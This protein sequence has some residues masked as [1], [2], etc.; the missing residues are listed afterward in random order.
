M[1][2]RV[3]LLAALSAMLLGGSSCSLWKNAPKG[4]SGATGGEQL[5]R[6]MWEE[7][8][9]K[10]WAELDRHLAPLFVST[11]PNATRDKAAS[12]EHWKQYDLQSV[13]IAEVQV[14]PAGADFIVTATVT[15]TGTAAGQPMPAQPVH[16]MTVWQ[17]V[18][19]GF[20]A[21]AHSD[22]LP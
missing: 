22:A 16:T 20:V 3:G 4:W 14:Q 8:R 17:P 2:K 9:A 6:L 12:I 18:K 11:S 21:V 1:L 10:N 7:I 19:E 15:A 5:E 13:N